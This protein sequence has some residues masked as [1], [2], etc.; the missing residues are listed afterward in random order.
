[1][2]IIDNKRNVFSQIGALT[3]VKDNQNIP[4]PKDSISSINNSKEIVPFLLD[5][6]VVMVGSEKLKETVGELMT[7]FVR[8][9]E[10]KLKSELKNQLIEFNHD[11]TLPA[12]FNATG[13]IVPAGDIDTYG[14]LKTDPNSQA[15]SLLF[16]DNPNDFEVKSYGAQVNAGT[17][18]TFNNTKIN[19]DNITNDFTYKPTN[20]SQTIGD[21]TNDYIDGLTIINEKEFTS[22]IINKIFGT[23]NTNQNK[24]QNQLIFE[25]KL[26]K[27]INKI[28]DEAESIAISDEELRQIELE[29]QKRLDGIDTVD[30][31]C[32]V[33]VNTVTLD[34]LEDMIAITTGS[35]DPLT[36]GNAY[37]DLAASGF[38]AD[39][40]SQA[41]ED[42]ETIKDG[43]LKTLINAIVNV[44]VSAVI[45]PPQIRAL[46]AM[47]S[48]FKNNGIPDIGNPIDDLEKR[49]KLADCLAKQAKAL[50]N[51]FL[52]N[53]IKQEML[54]LIIPVSK[55]ILKEKINQYLQI[56]RSLIGFI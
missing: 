39:E 32:G 1:M 29:A 28:I 20:P 18:V 7:G 35:T 30:V 48:A 5:L 33:L 31:G 15:G 49:R 40:E 10:P 11:Q 51:E 17:D 27:S 3:S 21:F 44:L 8:N 46:F 37:V 24:T 9:V 43:F 16:N 2:G 38:P 47:T 50:I 54:N 26:D 25:A 45:S 23:I 55:L 6:L 14:K 36:V 4:N 22:N 56:L 12:S 42:S 52:F 19:Y 13:I 41:K 53:L 34:S